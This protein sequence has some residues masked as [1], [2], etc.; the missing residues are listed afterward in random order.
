MLYP[1][2]HTDKD[3]HNAQSTIDRIWRKSKG[4][5]IS[6][7]GT[8]ALCRNRNSRFVKCIILSTHLRSCRLQV[9]NLP[10]LGFI[11]SLRH[12]SRHQSSPSTTYHHLAWDAPEPPHGNPSRLDSKCT[13]VVLVV[14]GRGWRCLRDMA[15]LRCW[16]ATSDMTIQLQ[17][18]TSMDTVSKKR[19]PFWQTTKSPRSIQPRKG[20]RS[21]TRILSIHL[22][23]VSYDSILPARLDLPNAKLI[24]KFDRNLNATWTSR[25]RLPRILEV[26]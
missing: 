4:H 15:M 19:R 24:A 5:G 26:G 2:T 14:S 9:Y 18:W 25:E 12:Q 3:Q 1:D 6:I 16:G 17:R 22:G 23:S 11:E 20:T 13:L 7:A 21:W 10:W 8:F